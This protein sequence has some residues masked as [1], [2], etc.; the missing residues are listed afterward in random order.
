MIT[1]IAFDEKK[2]ANLLEKYSRGY[3]VINLDAMENNMIS[4]HDNLSPGTKMLG[5]IKTNGY[6]HGS[7][8][9]GKMLEG[10]DFVFGYAVA[11]S[12]EAMQLRSAGLK[13]A[14]LIL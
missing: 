14:I 2:Y 4:M 7:V 10:L 11:S 3:A 6:G 5:V 1:S 8:R 13:K 9:V 12:E